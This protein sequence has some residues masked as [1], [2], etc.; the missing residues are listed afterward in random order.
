MNRSVAVIV[1]LVCVATVAWS[2]RADLSGLK[3]C[4]DPGHGGH[5][6]AN[7]RLVNPDPGVD[8]WESE[9]N[10]QKAL[11]LKALLEARRAVV[12]L[13]RTT[14]DYPNDDEPSLTARWTLANNNNV[15]WFHSIHSNAAG[16]VNTTTNYTLM[17][18]KENIPTRTAAFP[19]AVT[20][21]TVIGPAIRSA[22]RTTTTSTW[23]DYTFYGGPNGGFNLGVLTGLVMPGE[24]SEGS[25]HDF[26]PETRRLLNNDY[27]KMEAYALRNSFMQYFTVP[28]DTLGIV[29]GIQTDIAGGKPVNLT[30]VRLLP[31]GRVY[32]GDPYNNGFFMFDSLAPGNY[33]LRCETP[34]YKPDS[35]QVTVSPGATVFADRTLES[36]AAPR[37][38]LS[39][40]AEGDTSFSPTMPVELYFSRVMDTASVRASFSI[41]PGVAGTLN[42]GSSNTFVRFT[43]SAPLPMPVSFVLTLDTTAKSVGGF[44]ID[45]NG[46]GTSGDSYLLHFRTR[47]MD[48]I[49]PRVL[50]RYPDSGATV[51][52][53]YHCITITFDEPLNPATVLS[54]NFAVL[55]VGGLVQS[56]TLEYTESNGRGAVIMYLTAGLTPGASYMVRVSGVKDFAGNAI[57]PATPI[58][59]G[60]SVD[61]SA[62][63]LLAVDS[64]DGSN[65][66]W[67]QPGGAAGTTGIDSASFAP[68]MV[69]LYPAVTPNGGA[70]IL[71]FAWTTSAPD[72]LLRL[73]PAVASP[74]KAIQWTKRGAVL[75]AYVN[76]DG[77]KSQFRFAVEDS[78]EAFPGGTPVNKEVSPWYTIDWVGW[79]LVE[80]DMEHDSVGSWVGNRLLEGDLRFDGIQLRYVPGVSAPTGRIVLDQIQLAQQVIVGVD[81]LPGSAPEEFK[82]YANY[83]NPFNPSTSVTYTL[84]EGSVVS[85][86]VYDLLGRH[87]TSLLQERQTA[88]KHS[89][90]WDARGV[91]SGVYLL[92]MTA[93]GGRVRFVAVNKMVLLR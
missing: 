87:V 82:L 44:S 19:E 92:R 86:D 45:G 30:R 20:M 53:A 64:L 40:P 52:T 7:D 75:Q 48:V 9:S 62:R 35:T 25:F 14:N 66:Q 65:L 6:P 8:F 73:P 5:N 85:L 54:S 80:W 83:P 56:K 91:S 76:G 37:V 41:A 58:L 23:L 28:A 32:N 15:N 4:I 46:D 18:V 1:V 63:T 93:T 12:I 49:P 61:G 38:A 79:R 29:A 70:G 3:F 74:A 42:W 47:V 88:G 67:L 57:S 60:F 31:V 77:G 27:R 51:A 10:F 13:T 17:L 36:F 81:E 90:R 43:P 16:G 22:L 26:Y 69:P 34:G 2:Q 71:R 84:S 21:S 68:A 55:K 11:H 59:W 50:S 72:W 89:V 78:V 33:T 39:S 24:L